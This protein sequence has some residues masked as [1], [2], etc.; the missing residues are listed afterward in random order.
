[1]IIW[2]YNLALVLIGA[3][4]LILGLFSNAIKRAYLSEPLVA[5][6]IGIILGPTLS[7]LIDIT[8]WTDSQLILEQAARLTLAIGIMGVAL[9]LPRNALIC[10]WRPLV[11]LL[12][13]VMP[14]MWLVSGFLTF[15]ILGLPFWIAML[16]GATVTPTDPVLASTIVTGDIAERNL[17]L[18]L[19]NVLSMTASLT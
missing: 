6:V 10:Y 2:Q 8:T 18:H 1:M 17:P 9:R 5:V 16:V 7:N 13:V 11:V 12:G 15:Y 19:R 14:I 4:V 3:I